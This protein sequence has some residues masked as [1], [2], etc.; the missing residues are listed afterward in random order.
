[1]LNLCYV[2]PKS[3]TPVPND[4]KHPDSQVKAYEVLTDMLVCCFS[5]SLNMLF[6]FSL[7]AHKI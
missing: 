2:G 6:T 4:Q 1:M 7:Y 5:C 3:Y